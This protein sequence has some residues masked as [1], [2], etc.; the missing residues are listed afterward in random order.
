MGC[1][2]SGAFAIRTEWIWIWIKHCG[3]EV[4][5]M[6]V[7]CR[8]RAWWPSPSSGW[9]GRGCIAV[10][11]P[12]RPRYLWM[13]TFSSHLPPA[14]ARSR[15]KILIIRCDCL[16]TTQQLTVGNYHWWRVSWPK[17]CSQRLMKLLR[18]SC[19]INWSQRWKMPLSLRCPRQPGEQTT[20]IPGGYAW[21]VAWA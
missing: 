7:P 13:W 15:L 11:P 17:C 1:Q 9:P 19:H 3:Y 14:E 16:T 18:I 21:H 5:L 12:S 6:G 2:K 20:N 4:L 8:A 10:C